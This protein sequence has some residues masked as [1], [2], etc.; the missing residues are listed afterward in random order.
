ML[1]HTGRL[2]SRPS[3]VSES[4]RLQLFATTLA[5]VRRE[6]EREYSDF[7]QPTVSDA[8]QCP[9]REIARRAQ[10][11]R[12]SHG[13]AEEERERERDRERESESES[14]RERERD[15]CRCR[16]SSPIVVLMAPTLLST[17]RIRKSEELALRSALLLDDRRIFI[18]C[19]FW[20]RCMCIPSEVTKAAGSPAPFKA[21]NSEAPSTNSPTR[22]PNPEALNPE[23]RTASCRDPA[24]SALSVRTFLPARH[25]VLSVHACRGPLQFGGKR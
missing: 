2:L 7:A 14:E 13:C 6:R 16:L 5:F 17:S 11:S 8:H 21:R 24:S 15:A 22:S 19:S 18:V 25:T 12:R 4:V 3:L 23:P 1:Y 20:R 9:V 10:H